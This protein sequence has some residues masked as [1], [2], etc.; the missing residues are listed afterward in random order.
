M[1]HERYM[2]KAG[3]A[4]DL[5]ASVKPKDQTEPE[6]TAETKLDM[7]IEAIQKQA[8]HV[9]PLLEKILTAHHDKV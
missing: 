2:P 5:N 4:V 3:V 8:N 9:G 7:A 1:K 6:S